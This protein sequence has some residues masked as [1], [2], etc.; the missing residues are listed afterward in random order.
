MKNNYVDLLLDSEA[1][2]RK[3]GFKLVDV[4]LSGSIRILTVE[5]NKGH[6]WKTPYEKVAEGKALCRVCAGATLN[7]NEKLIKAKGFAYKNQGKCLSLRYVN[8]TNLM[9]WETK[10]GIRFL[11]S[12]KAVVD[13]G[14]WYLT[15]EEL[16]KQKG[17]HLTKAAVLAFNNGAKCLSEEPVK[18]GD[19]LKWRC[20]YGHEFEAQYEEVS[21]R[22]DFC[23]E[24]KTLSQKNKRVRRTNSRKLTNL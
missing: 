3:F 14:Y 17:T 16:E 21:D 5:C 6:Q 19:L 24:C 4:K 18:R 13:N 9:E 10:A 2:T 11:A 8:D 1:I 22:K 15:K 23:K 20:R 12:Y 7:T